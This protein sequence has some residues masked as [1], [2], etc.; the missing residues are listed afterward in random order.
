MLC[1]SLHLPN[2]A[3][4]RC[5]VLRPSGRI[6][7]IGSG[8]CRESV[9]S[10]L[11]GS[12]SCIGCTRRSLYIIIYSK[13]YM[14]VFLLPL[15]V[16]LGVFHA[17]GLVGPAHSRRC[18]LAISRWE[19]AMSAA[20]GWRGAGLLNRCVVDLMYSTKGLLVVSLFACLT[21]FT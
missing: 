3:G 1:H 13:K 20:S 5:Q 19:N 7:G 21:C 14:I 8:G 10:H 6:P 15:V 12:C 11:L 9:T 18:R 17:G 16:V 2:V 4:F